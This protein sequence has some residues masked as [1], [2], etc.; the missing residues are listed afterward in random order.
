MKLIAKKI[1]KYKI[2]KKKGKKT[3]SVKIAKGAAILTTT[4][5]FWQATKWG[6]A[7][8]TAAPTGVASYVIALV[9]P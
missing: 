5:V 2:V 4:Y 3:V 6:I 7:T 8:I 9:S 1:S